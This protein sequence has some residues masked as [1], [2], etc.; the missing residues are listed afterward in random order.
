[1]TLTSR[2]GEKNMTLTSREGGKKNIMTLTSRGGKKNKEMTGQEACIRK[3]VP[4][5][6]LPFY[7]SDRGMGVRAADWLYRGL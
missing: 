2:D 1:M 3:I 4:P 5:T 6:P 7:F